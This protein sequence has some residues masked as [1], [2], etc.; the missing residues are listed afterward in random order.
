MKKFLL[1]VML[2][3][4]LSASTAFAQ[5]KIAIIDLQAIVV[6]SKAGVKVTN[7]LR[8]LEENAT[9]KFQAKEA[10]VKKLAENINKQRASLSQ[11]AL[12]EKNLELNRQSVEL[13]RLQ[14]DLSTELQTKQA[15]KLD[16]LLKELEPVIS[17]YSKEKELD[18]VLIKQPGIM[19]Y[20]NPTIDI[21]KEVISRFDIKWSKKGIK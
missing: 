2:F 4:F 7:E 5:N 18:L 17:D 20:A 3:C 12:Q 6:Q 11:T 16:E 9:K 1:L 10:E 14:K 15:M 8:T 19:A 13:E 21:T